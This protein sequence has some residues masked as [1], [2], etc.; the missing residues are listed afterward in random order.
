[1]NLSHPMPR[2]PRDAVWSSAG[3]RPQQ[4]AAARAA[5]YLRT[6]GRD[7]TSDCSFDPA[8]TDTVALP[9]M[10]AAVEARFGLDIGF[11]ATA[12]LFSPMICA[13]LMRQ[14]SSAAHRRV[15]AATA[16]RFEHHHWNRRYRMF[17]EQG[18]FAADTDCTGTALAGLFQAGRIATS[19]LLRGGAEL[20]RAAARPG[21]GEH[22]L[23]PGVVMVYWDDGEEPKVALRGRKQD[24]AAACNALYALKL[25]ARA[26][27]RDPYGVIEATTR[28]I[29]DHLASGR[30]AGGTRYY[31]SPD[32]FL[33]F[34][35]QLCAHFAD[36][37]LHLAP[38]LA[39]A[40]RQRSA[41]PAQ[42][43]R[44]EDPWADL[45]VAQRVLAARCLGLAAEQRAHV[46]RLLSTQAW[47]GAWRASGFFSLGKLPVYFG[48][49]GLTTAFALAA[50]SD[51]S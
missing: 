32:T 24:P 42:P 40:V 48:S 22:G 45:N 28:Y 36:C 4:P 35:T 34:A 10:R 18:G 13:R 47:D 49:A 7:V 43:G 30:Y 51:A 26:G 38:G 33:Y 11:D 50:L 2:H 3:P 46:S 29:A 9:A 8:L 21:D 27:L 5:D 44:P 37:R 31:P 15:L 6:L 20:L 12:E 17:A 39:A 14:I 1:M 23:A 19:E 16:S 41:A 25:A